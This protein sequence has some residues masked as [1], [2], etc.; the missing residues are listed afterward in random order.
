MPDSLKAGVE[1]HPRGGEVVPDGAHGETAAHCGSA[2]TPARVATPRDKPSAENE[3]WRAALEIVAALRDTVFTDFNELKRAV[4]E[5]LEE[6]DARPFAKR[7]GTRRQV[8]EEREGP[9]L[10]PLPAVPYEVCEWV[11]GRKVQRSCHVAYGRNYY[12]VGHLAVGRT[13]GLRV[14]DSTAEVLLGGERLATHPPFPA[15]A[16]NRYSTHAGDLPGGRSYSDWDAG[17]IGRWADRV[18][19]SCGEVVDRIFQ[20]VDYEEQGL[21]AALAA[22]GLEHRHARP[23]L[24]RARR[25]ALAS[26][27]PSPRH[28]HLKPIL[29]AGQGLAAGARPGGDGGPGDDEAGCVRGADLCGEA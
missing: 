16:R 9:L 21:D 5:R 28:R 26:G 22:P 4:A 7:E 27:R 18:G 10:R 6:H 25:M 13:V 20:R 24:E 29:E 11:C 8:F 3:V 19:P 14:T 12:S 1:G 17:R 15:C 23:R 2:V